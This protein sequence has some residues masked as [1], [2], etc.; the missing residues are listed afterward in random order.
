MC[1]A[2]AIF[3]LS[4]QNM[5]RIRYFPARFASRSRA[6]MPAL[7][8]PFFILHSSFSIFDFPRTLHC[9]EMAL[10]L[11]DHLARTTTSAPIPASVPASVKSSKTEKV[12]AMAQA[13]YGDRM[14]Y[15]GVSYMDHAVGVLRILLPFEPDE[16]TIA[17][18]LLQHVLRLKVMTVST[19]EMDFGSAVRT[20]VSSLHLLSHVTTQGR[21]SS[22]DDLRLMLVSMSDDARML[23]IIL[24]ERTFVLEQCPDLPLAERKRICRDVLGLFAPVAARL[25]IHAF[26]QR[27]EGLAFPVLYPS[28]ALRIG[29]QLGAL[30]EKYGNFLP[31]AAAALQRTI[32]DQRMEARVE[33]RDKLSFSV[34]TKM[35]A[36]GVSS[37]EQIPDLFALRVIV[38]SVADCYQVLG[39]IHH[40]GRPVG[41]RFKDYIAFPKPNGY[42]SLHTTMARFPGIPEGVFVEV[43]IRTEQMHRE[44]E[45]GIAAHWSYK[46]GGIAERAMERVKIQQALTSQELLTTDQDELV[47]HIYVLTPKGDVVELP[48]GATPLDFAFQVHTALGISFRAA[49][50]NGKI[51]SIEDPL[52]NG[53]V[54]EILTHSRPRPS[55]EWLQ[56]LKM[57]SSKSRLRHYLAETHRDELIARGREM[58]NAELKGRG[59]P[60]LDPDLKLFRTFSGKQLDLEERENILAKV[61]QGSDRISAVLSRVNALPKPKMTLVKKILPRLQRKDALLEIEGGVQMPMKFAKCCKP[62]EKKGDAII[63]VITRSGDVMVHLQKCK[64]LKRGNPERRIGVKWR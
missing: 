15:S 8:M 18:C 27:L 23:P 3:W 55:A 11:A 48:E 47:D 19:L 7:R 62:Q 37:I 34:F 64:Q 63:G 32:R 29:E 14:H 13:A 9:P 6:R 60:P 61:G 21:R 10:T 30:R 24:A 56:Q 28:D 50:V 36:K 2:G 58:I 16:E 57:S 51:V 22:V 12:F 17:A 59:L 40:L 20:L 49:R 38:P 4:S 1:L 45:Y 46:E 25:G 31:E 5:N 39:L 26:K 33:G 41:N 35:K 42:Q 54:V 43:Q 53:D 52:E 44:A